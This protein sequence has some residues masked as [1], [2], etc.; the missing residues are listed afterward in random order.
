MI[1]LKKAKDFVYFVAFFFKFCFE[2]INN[3]TASILWTNIEFSFFFFLLGG[4]SS[5]SV[6]FLCL[7]DCSTELLALEL[8]FGY[9]ESH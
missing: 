3:D 7:A 5:S 8:P 1:I 4:V 6:K 2:L 9:K